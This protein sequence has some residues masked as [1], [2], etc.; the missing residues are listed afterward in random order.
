MKW[1]PSCKT[2]GKKFA[3][4]GVV[5]HPDVFYTLFSLEMPKAKS[6]HWKQKKVPLEDFEKAVGHIVAPMRYGSLS[7]NSPTVTIVWDVETLQFE[8]KGTY[9]VG[10]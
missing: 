3:Y 8:V 7:I 1:Q 6:K 2:G 10:Y 9:A 5:P 4:Q